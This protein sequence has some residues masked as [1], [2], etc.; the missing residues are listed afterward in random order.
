MRA[1]II[2]DDIINRLKVSYY[3]RWNSEDYGY[4]VLE[5]SSGAIFFSNNLDCDGNAYFSYRT[6]PKVIAKLSEDK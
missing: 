6:F 3:E 4:M 1:R 5:L 2:T